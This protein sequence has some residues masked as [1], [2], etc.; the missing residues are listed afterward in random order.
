MAKAGHSAESVKFV[1]TKFAKSHL[2]TT[3]T[4]TVKR[5]Q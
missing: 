5:G 4:E 2:E 3:V 1:T